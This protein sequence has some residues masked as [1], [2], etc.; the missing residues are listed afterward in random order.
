M[1][2]VRFLRRCCHL[3]AAT[4]MASQTSTTR[5]CTAT[6]CC[7]VARAFLAV[8]TRRCRAVSLHAARCCP[9]LTCKVWGTQLAWMTHAKP[10]LPAIRG[11]ANL[12]YMLV[13]QDRCYD[14]GS[15]AASAQLLA[16]QLQRL[17][18]L[19]AKKVL[20]L[21]TFCLKPVAAC[22]CLDTFAMPAMCPCAAAACAASCA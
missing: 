5:R 19:Q 21:K 2:Q 20:C 17:P 14:A 18:H 16:F 22:C 4:A 11:S 1:L 7:A 10:G 3:Q 9:G 8:I 6:S 15:P 13:A 12:L